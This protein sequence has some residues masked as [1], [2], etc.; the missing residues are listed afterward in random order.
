MNVLITGT[1]LIGC[2]VAKEMVRRGHRVLLYDIAPI[3]SYVRSVAGDVPVARGDVRDMPALI[4]VMRD[5]KPDV[6]FHSAALIGPK[7][8]ERPYTGLSINVGGAIA[9]G[10]AARLSGVRRVVF[11][12]SFAVYNWTLPSSVPISEDFPASQNSFYGCSKIACE[13]VLRAYATSYGNE[14][15]IVRFAQGYGRGHYVGGS[16]GGLAMHGVVE[17]AARGEAVRIE[18]RLF[19]INEYVFVEDIVQG[20]AQACEKPLRIETFNIGTGVLSTPEDVASCIRAVCP[21]QSVEVLP[22][23]AERPGQHR[24]QPLDITRAQQQLDY[25]PK[26]DLARGVASFIQE[27]RQAARA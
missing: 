12:S 22:G 21:G 24:S 10:E 26:F 9:V 6:V 14:L 5:L 11:A 13:Q 3:E 23:P 19:G 17:A 4:D 25:D 18:P 27:M 2:Y 16:A 20:V 7:V 1:G 15:A 8:A